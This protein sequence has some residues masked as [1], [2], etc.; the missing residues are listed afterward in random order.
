MST[1]FAIYLL[2]VAFW[3]G[4]V[5]TLEKNQYWEDYFTL[6]ISGGS[7]S[8]LILVLVIHCF[9]LFQ[10][11]C[12]EKLWFFCCWNRSS[13]LIFC[14]GKSFSSVIMCNYL[15]HMENTSKIHWTRISKACNRDNFSFRKISPDHSWYQTNIPLMFFYIDFSKMVE[16]YVSI[17]RCLCIWQPP[18]CAG[19]QHCL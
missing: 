3:D 1:F 9:K 17:K 12:S 10:L 8:N 16:K 18:R 15:S 6:H 13:N 7:C 14:W 4:D 11:S 2:F 19:C 5:T